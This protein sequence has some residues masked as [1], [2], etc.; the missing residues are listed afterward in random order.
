MKK[1]ENITQEVCDTYLKKKKKMLD[2]HEA[3][4][5]YKDKMYNKY[6]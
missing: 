3:Y 6:K 1:R 2:A 5:K 4:M